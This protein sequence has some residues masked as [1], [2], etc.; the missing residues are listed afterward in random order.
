MA[1]FRFTL[2]W[3][4]S[5]TTP[6]TKR[7][8]Q[9]RFDQMPRRLPGVAAE[10]R[11]IQTHIFQL[12]CIYALLIGIYCHHMLMPVGKAAHQ[13]TAGFATAADNVEG[14]LLTADTAGK[15][16]LDERLTESPVL[17]QR[18]QVADGI[19]P[20]HYRSIEREGDPKPLS[21]CKLVGI[22]PKP[23]VVDMK[24]TK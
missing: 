4:V 2:L 10:S 22:S 7:V 16:T 18:Q 23:M 3:L 14:R 12:Q 15:F 20:D 13:C 6:C 1:T 8:L 9:A 5:A 21:V 17:N 11:N 19:K 24:L